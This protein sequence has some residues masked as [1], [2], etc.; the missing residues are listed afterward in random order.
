MYGIYNILHNGV[1]FFKTSVPFP[2]PKEVFIWI[3]GRDHLLISSILYILYIN[4]IWWDRVKLEADTIKWGAQ[5]TNMT[6][7]S[8]VSFGIGPYHENLNVL[9]I[10]I[11]SRV[12]ILF[13]VRTCS[14]KT[15]QLCETLVKYILNERLQRTIYKC[16]WT[17]CLM[18]DSAYIKQPFT[19]D[20]IMK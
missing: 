16:P 1:V 19:M 11:Q 3:T 15:C 8:S 12:S 4:K 5:L 6:S 10:P 17:T 18:I 13:N 14:F 9:L 20:K 2:F 7:N